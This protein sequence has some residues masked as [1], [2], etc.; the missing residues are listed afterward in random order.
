MDKLCTKCCLPKAFEEFSLLKMGAGGMGSWC[1][2]CKRE[3]AR[4][5][6]KKNKKKYKDKSEEWQ[7]NNPAKAKAMKKKFKDS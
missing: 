5:H 2:S 6:Y 4:E 3:Y 1:K 7:K